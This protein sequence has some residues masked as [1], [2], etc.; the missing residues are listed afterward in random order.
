MTCPI[1]KSDNTEQPVYCTVINTKLRTTRQIEWPGYV[2]CLDCSHVWDNSE[3]YIP[4]PG[5][6]VEF[7]KE[8]HVCNGAGY[9]DEART[10]HR[11]VCHHGR[12][13]V[14]VS[15]EEAWDIH[16]IKSIQLR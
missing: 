3:P 2:K 7:W 6:T 15:A 8:C 10:S 1:C 9:I 4:E 13:L 12:N 5:G 16:G 11:C 14:R